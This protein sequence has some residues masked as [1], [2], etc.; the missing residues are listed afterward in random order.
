[1]MMLKTHV[2]NSFPV[3]TAANAFVTPRFAETTP[4]DDAEPPLSVDRSAADDFR[5][6][7]TTPIDPERVLQQAGLAFPAQPASALEYC[8]QRAQADSAKLL[9]GLGWLLRHV[10]GSAL[11]AMDEA[12]ERRLTDESSLI[13]RAAQLNVVMEKAFHTT[14]SRSIAWGR[15]LRE[16]YRAFEKQQKDFEQSALWQQVLQPLHVNALDPAFHEAIAIE[17]GPQFH[18]DLFQTPVNYIIKAAAVYPQAQAEGVPADIIAYRS[19]QQRQRQSFVQQFPPGERGEVSRLL[20]PASLANGDQVYELRMAQLGQVLDQSL[21]SP[22]SRAFFAQQLSNAFA[23]EMPTH[24][25]VIRQLESL[26]PGDEVDGVDTTSTDV[27][28]S[29]GTEA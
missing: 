11:V 23:L 6:L 8:W 12:I 1:M 22:E 29:E 2:G 7:F 19:L 9:N 28:N 10:D 3:R 4:P 27:K 26:L 25:E 20:D 15:L 5:P 18:E 13:D 21:T 24:P 17:A 16:S 14:D